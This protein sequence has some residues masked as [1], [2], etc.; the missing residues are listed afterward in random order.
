M[1]QE[2]DELQNKHTIKCSGLI[3]QVQYISGSTPYTL[4]MI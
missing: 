1:I 4:W 3:Q 2:F